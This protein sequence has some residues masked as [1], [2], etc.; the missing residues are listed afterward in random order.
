MSIN[1]IINDIG[2]I[3]D[4]DFPPVDKWD[5]EI[6]EGQEIKIDR[7]GNW[8]FNHSLIENLKLV[9]LFS[10]VLKKEDKEYFLVTPYEKVPVI[11]DIA[12]YMI[13]DFEFNKDDS[14]KLI[15][16]LNYSFILKSSNE[17]KLIHNNNSLIPIVK[18]RNEIEGFFSRSI[19][20]KLINLSIKNNQY[21]KDI[22][23]LRTKHNDL[24]VG[25]IA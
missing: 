22:L 15:T 4:A 20:Y 25:K 19:Y 5:P 7:D 13:V 12:P 23:I 3:D 21:K 18:V 8:F 2:Q 1:K 10:K 14:L 24:V 9:Y 17:S 11:V 6:C 16:N